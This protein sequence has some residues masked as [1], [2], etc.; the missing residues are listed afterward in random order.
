MGC[1]F[2][3]RTIDV[4]LRNRCGI[5]F[6]VVLKNKNSERKPRRPGVVRRRRLDRPGM[7]LVIITLLLQNQTEH[8]QIKSLISFSPLQ[9]LKV[10][11]AFRLNSSS[12]SKPEEVKSLP[13]GKIKKKH[14]LLS[15]IVIEPGGEESFVLSHYFNKLFDPMDE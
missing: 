10:M 14:L 13:G 5:A 9:F 2:L 3:P 12:A 11:K 8:K 4:E 1:G 15:T 7:A 6:T